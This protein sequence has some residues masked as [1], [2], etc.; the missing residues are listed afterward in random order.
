M[1]DQPK[2]YVGQEV[3]VIDPPILRR[4]VKVTRVGVRHVVTSDEYKWRVDTGRLAGGGAYGHR[5]IT[6]VTDTHRGSIRREELLVRLR[7]TRW[8]DKPLAVLEQIAT[9]LNIETKEPEL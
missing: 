8:D 4:I 6:P 7:Y 9:L 2:W 5:Y 1:T 3:A